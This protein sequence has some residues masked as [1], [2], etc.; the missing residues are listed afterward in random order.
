MT[1]PQQMTKESYRSGSVVDFYLTY[2]RVQPPEQTILNL[3]TPHLAKMR[4]L[5][6]GIGGGR[7]T[8][9]LAKKAQSYIGVDYSPE[10]VEE[11]A[12]RLEAEDHAGLDLR[13]M[14]ARD[15]QG[16]ADASFDLV[17]FSFNGVDSM[18]LEDR[19]RVLAEMTRV[20]AP[21]GWLCFSSHNLQS[22]PALTQVKFHR[23]PRVLWRRWLRSRKIKNL[24]REVLSR[25]STLD[26][27][28]ISDG[29]H[30]FKVASC[31]IRPAH[32]IQLL[33]QL[34]LKQVQTYSLSTGKELTT[35]EI[36]AC[37][38]PWLYYLCRKPAA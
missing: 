7:T 3:I 19:H 12:R 25:A 8:L 35:S 29:A 22:A 14:D 36:P 20:L 4:V 6:I 2:Q 21:D 10:M 1:S 24:N 30:D 34:G 17:L 18:P 31:Y 9:W 16:L 11:A 26:A 15:M 38:D 23:D 27:A 13:V 5:D 28:F 32:Q 37:R 33:E